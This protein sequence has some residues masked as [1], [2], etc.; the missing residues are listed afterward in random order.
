MGD[1][2]SV[3]D[4]DFFQGSTINIKSPCTILLLHKHMNDN[5]KGENE[6]HI[7]S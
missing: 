6:G 1:Y 3:L 7:D 2:V 4:N 5:I